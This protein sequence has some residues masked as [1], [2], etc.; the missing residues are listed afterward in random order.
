MT[1]T[2]AARATVTPPPLPLL[3][4]LRLRLHP[5]QLGRLQ[6]FLYAGQVANHPPRNLA[7]IPRPSGGFGGQA[8][9]TQRDQLGIGTA[10]VEPAQGVGQIAPRGPVADLRDDRG[11]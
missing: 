10:A 11:R 6:T 7:G 9:A 2:E 4:G 8:V 1:S 5:R 3:G